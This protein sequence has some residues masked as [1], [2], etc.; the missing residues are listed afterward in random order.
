MGL[1]NSFSHTSHTPRQAG[2]DVGGG[3][4]RGGGGGVCVCVRGRGEG[5]GANTIPVDTGLIIKA[6]YTY[7]IFICNI[8]SG[9]RFHIVMS[10][11]DNWQKMSQKLRNNKRQSLT[12]HMIRKSRVTQS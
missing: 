2:V 7:A 11:L 12:R 6:R 9:I 1:I 4:Y 10:K 3:E 5:G 8:A